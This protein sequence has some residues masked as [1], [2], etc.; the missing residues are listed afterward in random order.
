MA[1]RGANGSAEQFV[2]S[3]YPNSSHEQITPKNA[4]AMA[5]PLALKEPKDGSTAFGSEKLGNSAVIFRGRCPVE[6]LDQGV[7]PQSII[8]VPESS[9][10]P[11][12][13][14]TQSIFMARPWM[15]C[16]SHS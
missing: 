12:E 13:T 5:H 6:C 7:I 2:H 8:T 1:S 15:R 9:I 3:T 11:V 10:E 4:W 14:S 16:P